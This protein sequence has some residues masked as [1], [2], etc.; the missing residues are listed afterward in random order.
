VVTCGQRQAL[1]CL[2]SVSPQQWLIWFSW[3]YS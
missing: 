3:R 2:L 1:Q